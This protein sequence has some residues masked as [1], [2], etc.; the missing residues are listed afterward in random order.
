MGKVNLRN[1][2]RDNNNEDNNPANGISAAPVILP[3]TELKII[4]NEDLN[5]IEASIISNK[6]VPQPSETIISNTSE[7]T[8]EDILLGPAIVSANKD[9]DAE[10]FTPVFKAPP[11]SK[12]AENSPTGRHI[13]PDYAAN[14]LKTK[15]PKTSQPAD[16]LFKDERKEEKTLKS[17]FTGT[18]NLFLK[19]DDNTGTQKSL[20]ERLNIN[21]KM[22]YTA[23]GSAALASILIISYLNNFTSTKLFGSEMVYVLVAN[24]NISEK[25][26][27]SIADLAKKEIPKKFVLPNAIIL[28]EK[29]DPN[30]IVG[31]V[32]LTDIYES[33]QLI[34]KRFVKQEDS[35][36]LSP[37]VPVNHRAFTIPSKALSYIKPQDHVDVLVS[38]PDPV[39][40][41]RTIN[42]PVLQNALV[43]A[44]DGNYKISASDP[45]T[46]G[47]SVTIA[48]PNKLVNFFTIL[49]E[50]GNFQ[51][52]LR[53]D[54]DTTNLETKYSIAQ[55]EVMLNA[56]DVRLEKFTP[57]PL[58]ITPPKPQ[59]KPKQVYVPPVQYDVPAPV[60][61]PPRPVYIP[62]R[63]QVRHNPPAKPAVKAP[64]A[65][66]YEAPKP[67]TTVFVIN[68]TKIDTQTAPHSGG[69]H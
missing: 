21:K 23:S 27:L 11:V 56:T 68:G 57:E 17:I 28:D 16:S 6:I 4:S 3:E 39:D 51:L 30:T 12:K 33:E 55:L 63:P 14:T 65:P 48:V 35:P 50:K 38:I 43:L 13:N 41:S 7:S 69:K 32:A 9:N 60:Y 54:G 34:T 62:P 42:T 61:I 46:S 44:L 18:K 24:K 15:A 2:L 40:K 36:W 53:R 47:D 26:V 19:K 10:P 29:T 20:F 8:A 52:A 25:S 1:R 5:H 22:F 45:A 64:K 59:P 58:N 66:V 67:P 49:Q 31:Q 37:A